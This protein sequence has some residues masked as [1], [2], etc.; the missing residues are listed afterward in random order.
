M[1]ADNTAPATANG[2]KWVEPPKGKP[3]RRAKAPATTPAARPAVEV[4][5]KAAPT[6]PAPGA[7]GRRRKFAD[8]QVITLLAK[9]NPKRANARER[10]AFYRTGMT[11]GEYIKACRGKGYPLAMAERDLAWDSHRSQGYIRLSDPARRP[12]KA[13]ED[14]P[15]AEP[16]RPT[17]GKKK[18]GETTAPAGTV[19]QPP[20]VAVVEPPAEQP[21][22]PAT[23]QPAPAGGGDS[24]SG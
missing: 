15:A 12:A 17:S 18:H 10:F 23:D 22:A 3:E 2:A 4:S 24:S 21:P 9:E 1:T 19:E 13:A 5:R 8:S 6:V 11:V 16:K 14:K 7:D 20:V